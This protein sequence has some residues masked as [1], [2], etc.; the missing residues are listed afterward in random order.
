MCH[1]HPSG[2]STPS[3]AD[4]RLTQQV[5]EIGEMMGI[6]VLDHIIIGKNEFYSM[7]IGY[8]IFEKEGL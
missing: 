7:E 5:S 4:I 1:N 2:D 6:K 3:D 8:R